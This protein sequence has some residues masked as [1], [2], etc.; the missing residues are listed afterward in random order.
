MSSPRSK[1]RVKIRG[2][3]PQ[4]GRKMTG[5]DIVVVVVTEDGQEVT[6]PATSLTL[7]VAGREGSVLASVTMHVADVD[8]E[9]FEAALLI[10]GTTALV[11]L[12]DPK[13]EPDQ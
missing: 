9:P 11:S 3:A 13:P 12:L 7:H 8:I 5:R 6:L 4:G 1:G 2:R 10:G